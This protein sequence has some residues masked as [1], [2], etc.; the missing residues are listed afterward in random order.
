MIFQWHHFSAEQD[1]A[2]PQLLWWLW[3]RSCSVLTVG[4]SHL[5]LITYILCLAS[6][7]KRTSVCHWQLL[8]IIDFIE[9][10]QNISIMDRTNHYLPQEARN[11]FPLQTLGRDRWTYLTSVWYWRLNEE[12]K[13]WSR[14]IIL[15]ILKVEKKYKLTLLFRSKRQ[16]CC[17]SRPYFCS[18]STYSWPAK[19][20][21]TP[22]VTNGNKDI[23]CSKI[24]SLYITEK[25]CLVRT[26]VISSSGRFSSL[27][28]IRACWLME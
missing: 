7:T 18:S 3:P 5:L 19:V 25:T 11:Q 12:Y 8:K 26:H 24:L 10:F 23:S 27:D 15:I 1:A 9:I 14:T 17:C 16:P 22:L 21:N 6:Y 2:S 13:N 28:Q 20:Q 4:S